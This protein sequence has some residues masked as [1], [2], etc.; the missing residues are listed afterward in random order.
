MLIFDDAKLVYLANPKTGTTAIERAFGKYANRTLSS[1]FGKH[2]RFPALQRKMP[3]IAKTYDIVTVVRD[4]LDTL[5]SWYR[6]RSRGFVVPKARRTTQISFADF[7]GL[8][9]SADPPELA[10]VSTSVEFVLDRAGEIE[11]RLTIFKYEDIDI[12]HDHLQ[13]RL[14]LPS[15]SPLRRVNVSPNIKETRTI[16]QLV[17]AENEKLSSIYRLY[18]NIQFSNK[19]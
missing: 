4:P 15:R 19:L 7:F 13:R 2:A 8:W 6:Y 14:N 9:C 17:N 3:E 18:A 11:N 5:Y 10:R 16:R 12:L 1:Q